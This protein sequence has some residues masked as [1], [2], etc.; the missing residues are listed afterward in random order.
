MSKHILQVNYKFSLS[1]E[2]LKAMATQRAETIA[3]TVK[4]LEWKMFLIN[5]AENETGGIYMFADE[6]SLN[7][8]IN[9]PVFS[10]LKSNPNISDI[11]AKKFTNIDDATSVTHG[12]G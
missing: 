4:G 12:P 1:A 3:N 5:E 9:G 11:N 10:A 2:E 7:N 6:D 8:Y